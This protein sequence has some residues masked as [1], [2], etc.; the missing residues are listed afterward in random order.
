[1]QFIEHTHASQCAVYGGLWG[2]SL[3]SGLMREVNRAQDYEGSLQ[4]MDVV[5]THRMARREDAR[6][7]QSIST[8]LLHPGGGGGGGDGAFV[9]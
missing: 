6:R 7:S 5:G 1:M 9:G 2:D 4:G 3:L 8:R